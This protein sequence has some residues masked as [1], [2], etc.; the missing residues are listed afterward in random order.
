MKMSCRVDPEN[1]D[2]KFLYKFEKGHT[3]KSEGIYVAKM[4]LIPDKILK[5]AKIQSDLFKE[6]IQQ[7]FN[8]M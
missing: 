3:K 5:R 4:A 8:K 2:V 7:L 1:G 6:K